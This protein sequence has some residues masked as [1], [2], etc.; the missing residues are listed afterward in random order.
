MVVTASGI[1]H[2]YGPNSSAGLNTND[3]E[4]SVLFSIG[5]KEYCPRTSAS[6]IWSNEVLEFNVFGWG[7]VVVSRYLEGDQ[8]VWEYA[9]GSTT[10]MNRICALPEDQKIPPPRGKRIQLF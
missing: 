2:D 3:T 9:D 4:G 6:M 8:L 5:D 1:I 10:H 7:P